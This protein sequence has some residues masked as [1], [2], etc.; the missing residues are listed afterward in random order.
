MDARDVIWGGRSQDL[1]DVAPV[2][3]LTSREASRPAVA[4]RCRPPAGGGYARARAG[5]ASARP[6]RHQPR[7][8]TASSG[9]ARSRL[10]HHHR[11]EPLQ[12]VGARREHSRDARSPALPGIS[13]LRGK[14]AI[15]QQRLDP[16]PP[17]SRGD[18]GPRSPGRNTDQ[19]T[20]SRSSPS[21][22][23]IA[24]SSGPISISHCPSPRR[25]I[26]A[27]GSSADRSASS[28]DVA[29]TSSEVSSLRT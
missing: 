25:K 29:C 6:R 20:P 24:R 8:A 17:A 4:V 16:R 27:R 14:G 23:A 28:P 12:P 3:R 22:S 18:S 21:R 11:G 2:S 9:R 10:E 1:V 13:V 15:A 7:F 5:T 19:R 26:V